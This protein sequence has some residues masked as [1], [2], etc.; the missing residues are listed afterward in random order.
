MYTLNANDLKLG[1][2]TAIE[3]AL[4][5]EPEV[6]ISVRG[7]RRFVVMRVEQY[8]HLRECELEA[9][10][11]A[12]QA[13][14]VAGRTRAMT[15]VQH[16][17]DMERRLWVSAT[18]LSAHQERTDYRPATGAPKDATAR[19]PAARSK[20]AGSGAPRTKAKPKARQA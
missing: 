9:A 16:M 12:A 5:D 3:S 7:E 18:A 13:D 20:S 15:A 4:R 19:K 17:A 6:A 8:Q 2:V 10:W 14:R 1:G 11:L